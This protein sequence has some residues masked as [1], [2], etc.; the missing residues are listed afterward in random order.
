[1]P[2]KNQNLVK[3]LIIQ[4]MCL[5]YETFMSIFYWKNSVYKFKTRYIFSTL[6]LF[7]QA[8]KTKMEGDL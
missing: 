8:K 1:M 2:L 7:S 6:K 3:V 4:Y 5:N